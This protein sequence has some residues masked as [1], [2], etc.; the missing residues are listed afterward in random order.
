MLSDLGAAARMSFRKQSRP[1]ANLPRGAVAALERIM[2]DKSGLEQM[3]FVPL[4]Q[5]LDGCDLGSIARYRQDET[6]ID[7][8][9]IDQDG[10]R[11]ALTLIATFFRSDKLQALAQKVQQGDPWRHCQVVMGP[12]MTNDTGKPALAAD[13]STGASHGV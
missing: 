2:L 10:T 12:L 4:R 5:T 9:A 8:D 1:R 13:R 3:Q 11:T 6:R 7:P